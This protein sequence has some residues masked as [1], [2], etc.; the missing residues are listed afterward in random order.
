MVSTSNGVAIVVGSGPNGLAAAHVLNKAGYDVTVYEANST[1]GGGARASEP[2]LGGLIQDHCAAVH[3]LAMVS[4][5]L[6]ELDV[7]VR[8]GRAPVECAHPLD[9][10]QAAL[11]HRSLETTA[12][13][14]GDG[15]AAW[16]A[17][18]GAAARR[19][20]DL[21][22]DLFSP[23][24][25]IPAH[26]LLFARFGAVAAAPPSVVARL[27]RSESA[28]ALYAG[29][30]AHGF[31]PHT[32]PFG[33]AVAAALLTAAHGVGWPVVVGGTSAL[34]D[35]I[36]QQLSDRGVSFITGHRVRS[37]LDLPPHDVLMLDVHPAQIAEILRGE[38]PAR[39]LR[40]LR[41]FRGGPAAHKV[42]FVVE[43]G[44]PWAVPTVSQAGTVHVGGSARE[45]AAAEADISRG[46]MPSRPFVLV[47]QQYVADPSRRTRGRVPVYAYAHV[48][49]GYTGDATDALV[50]QIERFA[51]GFRDRIVLQR[52]HPTAAAESDN[53]NFIGGDILTGAKSAAQLLFGPASVTSP[54]DVGVPG[55]FVCSAA[56]PPGPGVHGMCGYNAAHRALRIRSR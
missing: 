30:A 2:L 49:H 14:L 17:L 33:G 12:D 29:I 3:P 47:G 52:S 50:Q 53:L 45:I 37:R 46:R 10:G 20:D 39:N 24:I 11:L 7:P 38:L 42:D 31:Q 13:G 40:R 27:L 23:P 28:A 21:A 56:T 4:P 22:P 1:L 48:P 41:R 9:G 34:T 19:F 25:H 8:W 6:A 54:Y 15:A 35:A 18:F 44:I 5:Y 36:V 43:G 55:V 26:P 51:P 32:K 16:R